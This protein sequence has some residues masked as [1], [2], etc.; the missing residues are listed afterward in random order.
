MDVRLHARSPLFCDAGPHTGHYRV[1]IT[2]SIYLETQE[3]VDQFNENGISV[4][5]QVS[6]RDGA[7][8]EPK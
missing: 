8:A 6:E 4:A 7:K 2:G 3:E 1:D 5:L